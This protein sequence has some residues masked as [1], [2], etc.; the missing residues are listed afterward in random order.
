[1]KTLVPTRRVWL[2]SVRLHLYS[3]KRN[4]P[5]LPSSLGSALGKTEDRWLGVIK[6]QLLDTSFLSGMPETFGGNWNVFFFL[7]FVH[8]PTA[9]LFVIAGFIIKY[10]PKTLCLISTHPPTH[11]HT[12]SH[13]PVTLSNNGLTVSIFQ[14]VFL[15]HVDRGSAKP[16]INRCP[17]SD[18]L[19]LFSH[20]VQICPVLLSLKL[21]LVTSSVFW[22]TCICF[23][24]K[25]INFSLISVQHPKKMLPIFF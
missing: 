11:T 7:M 8:F 2:S 3:T 12:Y 1:M 6:D 10:D 16:L 5:V 9:L 20:S 25:D 4:K 17:V 13:T 14:C 23:L 19:L 15:R 22:K 24:S 18:F 21:F